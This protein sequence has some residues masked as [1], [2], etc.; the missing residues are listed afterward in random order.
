MT[1]CCFL[2]TRSIQNIP[3][4]SY[5]RFAFIH[6]CSCASKF[7]CRLTLD[8]FIFRIM[9]KK[10]T[11]K[12][13][14]IC[15]KSG[16]FCKDPWLLLHFFFRMAAVNAADVKV[17]PNQVPA[18]NPTVAIGIVVGLIFFMLLCIYYQ[19]F[20]RKDHRQYRIWYWWHHFLWHHHFL[21]WHHFLLT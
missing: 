13:P 14:D 2:L 10:K 12:N 17:P 5:E 7:T 19:Q 21:W 3:A 1:I 15:L 8:G 16:I 20:R 9:K 6:V 4:F 18:I 11:S